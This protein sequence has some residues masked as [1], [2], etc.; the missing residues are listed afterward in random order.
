MYLPCPRCY[1]TALVQSPGYND[2]G[3]GGE[4]GG[5]KKKGDLYFL[6]LC[7]PHRIS[8]SLRLAVS[9]RMQVDVEAERTRERGGKKKKEG[10]KG[11]ESSLAS[12]P[13]LSSPMNIVTRERKKKNHYLIISITPDQTMKKKRRRKGK[14]GEK[15]DHTSPL[16]SLLLSSPSGSQADRR[17]RRGKGGNGRATSFFPHVGCIDAIRRERGRGERRR[18]E[19]GILSVFSSLFCL[20]WIRE[21]EKKGEGRS[22]VAACVSSWRKSGAQEKEEEEKKRKANSPRPPRAQGDRDFF[23]PFSLLPCRR[24]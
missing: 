22:T 14:E 17:G 9:A 1:R 4:G 3:R 8:S 24:A 5:R 2:G 19:L 21:S 10:R 23:P 20:R 11:E 15:R 16:T 12:I 7:L 18:E 6:F 13:P